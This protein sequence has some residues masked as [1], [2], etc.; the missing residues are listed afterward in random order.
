V[1][2]HAP[3]CAARQVRRR[4]R[5]ERVHGAAPAEGDVSG[6]VRSRG[7]APQGGSAPGRLLSEALSALSELPVSHGC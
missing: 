5:G 3:I 2:P 4:D 6:R 1:V 7:R